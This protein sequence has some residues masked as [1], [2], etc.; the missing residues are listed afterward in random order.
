M[1]VGGTIGIVGAL[2]L[3]VMAFIRIF[4]MRQITDL[5]EDVDR[6]TKELAEVRLE[7]SRAR[8]EKHKARNDLARSLMALEVVRR[9]AEECTCGVLS[10]VIEII[11]RLFNELESEDPRRRHD[12]PP[13]D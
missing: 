10:P 13:V 11:E 2:A 1:G 6:N 5:R 7:L 9:L 12:D 8:S 3:A 4:L